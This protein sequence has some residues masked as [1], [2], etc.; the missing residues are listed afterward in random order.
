MAFDCRLRKAIWHADCILSGKGLVLD[1]A[2]M[3]V[4]TKIIHLEFVL[5]TCATANAHGVYT[6]HNLVIL[7]KQKKKR[8][9]HHANIILYRI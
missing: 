5:G 2:G 3:V 1:W 8:V 7:Q 4:H 9:G 6:K